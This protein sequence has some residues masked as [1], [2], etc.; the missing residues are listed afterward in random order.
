MH[1]A[2]YGKYNGIFAH[3]QTVCTRSLLRGEGGGGGG[4]G[5]RLSLYMNKK[6][7]D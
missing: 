7:K 5:M 4:L 1:E 2:V 3:A 6:E